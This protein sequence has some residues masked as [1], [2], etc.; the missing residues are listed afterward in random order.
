MAETARNVL[1]CAMNRRTRRA[2]HNWQVFGPQVHTVAG[3]FRAVASRRRRAFEPVLMT[4]VVPY[5]AAGAVPDSHRVPFSRWRRTALD[6]ETVP[7]CASFRPLAGP[8]ARGL[9]YPPGG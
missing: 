1:H 3:V 5:S 4:A 8:A 9:A 7:T 6:A 2:W